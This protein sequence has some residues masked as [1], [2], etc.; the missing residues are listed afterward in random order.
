MSGMRSAE[1]VPAISMSPASAS[2][3]REGLV[4]D[5]RL[6]LT[7]L[8]LTKLS[9][10]WSRSCGMPTAITANAAAPSRHHRGTGAVGRAEGRD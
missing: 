2:Q 9:L 3:Q 6:G 8:R 1:G 10:I 5:Q 7:V 4:L